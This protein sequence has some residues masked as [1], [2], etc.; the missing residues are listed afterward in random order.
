MADRWRTARDC[1]EGSHA[2]KAA[3][4]RYLPPLMGHQPSGRD[5][6]YWAYV[7]RALFFE[8]VGRTT[9]WLGRDGFPA[10]ADHRGARR[11]RSVG[12]RL[13]PDG[14]AAGGLRAGAG[15]R[16][17]DHRPRRGVGRPHDRRDRAAAVPEALPDR[18]N[19]RRRRGRDRR[20]VRA[21]DGPAAR[22]LRAAEGRRGVRGRDGRPDPGAGPARRR[23][24]AAA[25]PVAGRPEGGLDLPVGRGGGAGDR[26]R[27]ADVHPVLDFFAQITAAGRGRSRRR[28]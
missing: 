15:A 5:D 18:R 9:G 4:S 17:D 16:G 13:R 24:P 8:A 20:R 3:G 11:G 26:R 23:L 2:V 12:L 25:V 1:A 27:A 6:P 19:L 21:G 14:P 22:V 28:R 7:Q 10:L